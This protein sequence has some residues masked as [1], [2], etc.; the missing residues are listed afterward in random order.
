[1]VLWPTTYLVG[2][3]SCALGGE[4][5]ELDGGDLCLNLLKM[6]LKADDGVGDGQPLFIPTWLKSPESQ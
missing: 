1:M 2:R 5:H 4:E 6:R 3:G